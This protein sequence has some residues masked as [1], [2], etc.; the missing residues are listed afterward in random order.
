MYLYLEFQL[1]MRLLFF[2]GIPQVLDHGL[3]YQLKRKNT[4]RYW[5]LVETL[6]CSHLYLAIFN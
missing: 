5:Y 2:C 6:S 4:C 1:D 3:C